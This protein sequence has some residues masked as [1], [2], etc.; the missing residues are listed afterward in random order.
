MVFLN[1]QV[2]LSRN[3]KLT[4]LCGPKIE[5]NKSNITHVTIACKL[6]SYGAIYANL[7]NVLIGRF[8]FM[9]K[10]AERPKRLNSFKE[11]KCGNLYGSN[12]GWKLS[13]QVWSITPDRCF[14]FPGTWHRKMSHDTSSHASLLPLAPDPPLG[15][16]QRDSEAK[17]VFE[18]VSQE[19]GMRELPWMQ[20]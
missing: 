10:N 17:S 11:E 4:W 15:Y 14:S 7:Q 20:K 18:R 16:L 3:V 1:V 19:M 12:G 9:T 8:V 6:I 2:V 5:K 13:K